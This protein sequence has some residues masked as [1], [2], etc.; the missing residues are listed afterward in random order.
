MIEPI[1]LP[2]AILN[3]ARLWH[4]DCFRLWDADGDFPRISEAILVSP[5]DNTPRKVVLHLAKRF[6]VRGKTFIGL[7]S[8]AGD[9]VGEG[10]TIALDRGEIDAQRDPL[11]AILL[12]EMTHAVDPLFEE[13]I[14]RQGEKERLTDSEDL[15]AL[16]SEQRAFSAMWTAELQE[17]I[18]RGDYRGPGVFLQSFRNLSAEFKGF[19]DNCSVELTDQT[20]YHIRRIAADLKRRHGAA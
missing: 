8:E 11:T 4:D 15:Y 13:D 1:I 12:H 5:V 14:R 9:V 20:K 16:P 7:R 10:Y 18:A 6:G 2:D 3:Q 17:E 19:W